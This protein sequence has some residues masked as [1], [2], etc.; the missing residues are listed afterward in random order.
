MRQPRRAGTALAASLLVVAL[1][2][3]CVGVALALIYAHASG[4]VQPLII[5]N[6]TPGSA[7]A[8]VV[9][10]CSALVALLSYPLPLMP[11]M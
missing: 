3:A 10:V 9:E 8:L 4:G 5:M 6:L 1:L 2:Y 7:E 11:V